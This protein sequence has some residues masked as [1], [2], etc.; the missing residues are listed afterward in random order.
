MTVNWGHL[1]PAVAVGIASYS[2]G[3]VTFWH[4]HLTEL[5]SVHSI[6]AAA[7]LVRLARGVSLG[8]SDAI[9]VADARKLSSMIKILV[10]RLRAL[11][12]IILISMGL[13]I[14]APTILD[15]VGLYLESNTWIVPRL[16]KILSMLIAFLVSFSA[17]RV[18]AVAGSDVDL[19][20][21][22]AENLIKSACEKQKDATDQS[23]THGRNQ[24]KKS[25]R[26]GYGKLIQ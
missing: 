4:N 26:D 13:L 17:L 11:L 3:S 19:T 8:S 18:L 21:L 22:Q 2:L 5:L 16:D 15:L 20:D 9:T 23:L 1:L 10:R 14:F 6:F 24:E 25:S 7:I 12:V